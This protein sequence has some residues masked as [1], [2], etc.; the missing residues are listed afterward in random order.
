M[1]GQIDVSVNHNPN[2]G[3]IDSIYAV[4]GSSNLVAQNYAYD[5]LGNLTDRFDTVNDVHDQYYYDSLNRLATNNAFR[6]SSGALIAEQSMTYDAVGN[7]L[8]KSDVEGGASYVYD[9]SGCGNANQTC[10]HAVSKIGNQNFVYDANGNMTSG[11]GRTLQYNAFDKPTYIEKDGKTTSFTYG[12]TRSRYKRVDNVSGATTTTYYVQGLM[13]IVV[14]SGTQTKL[15]LGDYAVVTQQD[16]QSD[17]TRY[18]LKDQLG[19]LIA[20]ADEAGISQ[21]K[22]NYDAWGK[23]RHL[24]GDWMN[25][26]EFFSFASS[27]VTNR[28]YTG[29][30][31]LNEV[32]LIHMNGRVFDPLIARFISADPIIQAPHDMQ[33]YN[34]YAYVRNNPLKYTDPSGFSWWS[35]NVTDKF[36]SFRKNVSKAWRENWKTIVAVGLAAWG[37][38]AVYGAIMN[39]A[40]AAGPITA[41]AQASATIAASTAAGAASG[42]IMGASATALNGGN[43]RDVISAG[44]TGG[45]QGAVSGA[46]FGGISAFSNGWSMGRV[47][48]NG[49]AGGISSEVSGG[50][51]KD[52]A[53]FSFGMAFLRALHYKRNVFN[54]KAIDNLGAARAG[55]SPMRQV[56]D[57]EA[58]AHMVN[59]DEE[60]AADYL[61]MENESYVLKFV[62]KGVFGVSESIFHG[63]KYITDAINGGTWNV[64]SFSGWGSITKN[65]WTWGV[66]AFTGAG[67]IALDVAPY[68]L[69]GNQGTSAHVWSNSF[70][71]DPRLGS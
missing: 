42:A 49:V 9:G 14:G 10:A 18:L 22:L 16:G 30:E 4:N 27:M 57:K 12:P 71:Y 1:G 34:R 66:A 13:E 24:D 11:Y 37:G 69:W 55:D 35:E 26:V 40:L 39:S 48:A 54:T 29:H 53:K 6:N 15:Y 47:A 45:V 28:G 67:H 65:P 44:L 43:L 17:Q 52:G 33:S 60:M 58:L 50:E 25:E 36:R 41:A 70:N 23:R 5:D 51:F 64:I 8:T 68:G 31:H 56:G 20:I 7:I 46:M 59:V 38:W 62:E 19:S 21:E 32:G 3:L 2:S 61:R 63:G